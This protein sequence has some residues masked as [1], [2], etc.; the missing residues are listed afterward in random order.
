MWFEIS[1]VT[2]IKQDKYCIFIN[3]IESSNEVNENIKPTKEDIS[4]I[5]QLSKTDNL[6][7]LL[8]NSLMPDIYGEG[9]IRIS[10]LILLF[11]GNDY[12]SVS[13]L[14]RYDINVHVLIITH[15]EKENLKCY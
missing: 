12:Y 11:S 5:K 2:T 14:K 3:N 15:P 6:L 4:E 13:Q 7:K 10:I 8:A 9:E 1:L